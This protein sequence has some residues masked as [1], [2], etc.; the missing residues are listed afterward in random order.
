MKRFLWN[1]KN[2]QLSGLKGK[3]KVR[4]KNCKHVWELPLWVLRKCKFC[5]VC[6]ANNGEKLIHKT[7]TNSKISGC[8]E[9][10]SQKT[11][12]NCTF[13][14]AL[15]YDFY[16]PPYVE[17]E[18]FHGGNFCI[19]YDGPQHYRPMRFSQNTTEEDIYKNWIE[20]QVK[21]WLKD[22]YCIDNHIALIRVKYNNIKVPN[23]T[24]LWKNAYVVGEKQ[25]GND[26]IKL[27]NI[28][29]NDFVNNK[30]GTFSLGFGVFCTFKCCKENPQIC[31][32]FNCSSQDL[33]NTSISTVCKQYEENRELISCIT[34]NGL[35]PLDNLKEV[36]WF[37]QKFREKSTDDIFLWTGYTK[38]ECEPLIYLI[39][40]MNWVNIIIKFG[41][42][43]PNSLSRFDEILGV[44]LASDNQYAEKIS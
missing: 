30:K 31:Q 16:I 1:N 11:F 18:C 5:P 8:E 2:I 25:G 43:I 19:E 12:L 28:N 20:T 6:S 26:K 33:Y 13:K 40:K 37:I 21:D 10:E 29:P 41:R 35:E 3:I 14:K 38:E 34:I 7:L 42:Y 17:G 4:C 9:V 24:D 32:N 27:L 15:R 39:K 36:L 44:K 23:F 22:K